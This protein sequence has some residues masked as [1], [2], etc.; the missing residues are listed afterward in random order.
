MRKGEG[1][2]GEGV[3]KELRSVMYIYQYVMMNVILKYRKHA[4][5]KPKTVQSK[6][7]PRHINQI[8]IEIES[9]LEYWGGVLITL[10]INKDSKTL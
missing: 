6:Q 5:I 1:R 8:I 3:L 7:I 9:E 2:G 10:L 4:R